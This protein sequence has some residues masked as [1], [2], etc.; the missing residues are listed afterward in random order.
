ML[1][2][3]VVAAAQSNSNRVAVINGQTITQQELDKAAAEELKGLEVRRLQNEATL[4]QDKQ[5]ILSKTLED[6]VADKLIEAEA[7]KQKKTKEELLE[8]EV[9]SN[10]E[11]PS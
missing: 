2:F 1:A 11:T 10:V 9:N 5:Q 4:A 7:A 8:A 3:A 6:I